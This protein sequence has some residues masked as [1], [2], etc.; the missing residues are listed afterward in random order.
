[1]VCC[2]RLNLSPT[3]ATASTPSSKLL[4]VAT[5]VGDVPRSSD[6]VNDSTEDRTAVDILQQ[7]QPAVLRQYSPRA[8]M[9]DGN[10]CYWAVA[11]GMY[12]TQHSA[13]ARTSADGCRDGDPP[14]AVR[15]QRS[16]VLRTAESGNSLHRAIQ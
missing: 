13:H 8:M 7:F 1:M 11:L 9:G 15:R 5:Y 6:A 12:G 2:I 14:A 3:P 4:L 16:R 10:C